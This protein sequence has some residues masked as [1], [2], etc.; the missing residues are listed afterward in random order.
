M[1]NP[2]PYLD[3]YYGLVKDN[4]SGEIVEMRTVR[5]RNRTMAHYHMEQGYPLESGYHMVTRRFYPSTLVRSPSDIRRD[6]KAGTR[7]STAGKSRAPQYGG[8]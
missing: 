5:A 8:K 6:R 7:A 3:L 2:D 4:R 1:S